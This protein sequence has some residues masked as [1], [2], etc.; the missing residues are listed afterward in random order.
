MVENLFEQVL[1]IQLP[2]KVKSDDFR[3]AENGNSSPIVY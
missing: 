2:W 1:N 3:D